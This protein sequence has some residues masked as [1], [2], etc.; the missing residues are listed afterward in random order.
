M[1]EVADIEILNYFI[2]RRRS[3][4]MRLSLHARVALL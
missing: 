2:P 1:G 3:V 4:S